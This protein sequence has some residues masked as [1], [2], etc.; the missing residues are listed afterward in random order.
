MAK[1]DEE[2]LIDLFL[3]Q[4]SAITGLWGIYIGATF[5]GA[6]FS[7]TNVVLSGPAQLAAAFGFLA[8]AIGHLSLVRQA[9]SVNL[10][11]KDNLLELLEETDTP[12]SRV[13]RHLAGTAN[14]LIVS[15]VIHLFI[16]ACVFMLMVR[17]CLF[18]GTCLLW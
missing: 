12:Y 2:V 14:P 17:K 8:F 9:L 7:V 1:S 15:T 6:A 16:D 5:T 18:S 3:R 10:S 11:I 13:V 4:N